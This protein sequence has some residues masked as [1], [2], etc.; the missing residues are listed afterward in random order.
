MT[1]RNI[2][3]A[4]SGEEARLSGL[5]Y[6]IKIAKYHDGW[7][8]GVVPH[9]APTIQTRFGGQL[10]RDVIEQIRAADQE[11]VENMGKRFYLE[12]ERAGYR[13]RSDFVELEEDSNLMLSEFARSFDLVVTG[14]QTSDA[15]DVHLAANPDTLALQSGRPVLIVPNAYKSEGLAKHA[16]VAWD[17]KRAA[18]RALGDA[19]PILENKAK[20]TL[21]SVGSKAPEGIDRVLLNLERHG[22]NAEFAERPRKKSV[23]QTVLNTM[24]EVGAELIVMGAYEHS[25][26]SH[27]FFGGVTTDIMKDSPVPVFMSH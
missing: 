4:Y 24:D 10:P 2:L 9:S 12:A 21:L 8:T 11:R 13:D 14:V 25:K 18:A 3:C 23:G 19:M 27:D 5:R 6:A 16:I 7:L 26:F 20:V 1:T 17:G 22:I 15:G